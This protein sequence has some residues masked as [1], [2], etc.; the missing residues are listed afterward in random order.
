M[1]PMEFSGC[2]GEYDVDAIGGEEKNESVYDAE[3]AAMSFS[4]CAE[5]A[6]PGLVGER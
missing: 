1:F 2:G 6:R 3:D 5:I 4:W